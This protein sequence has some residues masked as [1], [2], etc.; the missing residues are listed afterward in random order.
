MIDLQETIESCLKKDN[1]AYKA[2][3]D[4]MYSTVYKTCMRYSPNEMVAKDY[5]QECFIR[6]FDKLEMFIG[7]TM[8][9]LGAWVKRVCINYCIDQARGFKPTFCEHVEVNR[10][11]SETSNHDL[12]G[13]FTLSEILNAIHK[14]SPRYK[15]V[16]NMFVLDGYT[17]EE[18]TR[19]LGLNPG[20]SKANL[21]KAKRRLKEILLATK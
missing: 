7:D 14:L 1:K 16:F 6:I 9:E 12:G 20:A 2:L 11:S 5:I 3:Y 21:F 17:H 18:I 8:A 13:E 10:L 15:T 4:S 19:E